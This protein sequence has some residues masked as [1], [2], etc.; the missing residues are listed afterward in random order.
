MASSSTQDPRWSPIS[1]LGRLAESDRREL[2]AIGTRHTF[3]PGERVMTEGDTSCHVEL[4]QQGYVKVTSLTAEFTES[5]LAIRGPGDIVGE[6]AAISGNSRSATVTTCGHV[7]S[8]VVR[9]PAFEAFLI[10]HPHTA[11]QL[12][13]TVGD[14]L[15]WANRRRAEFA[16]SSAK[17]RIARVLADLASI[18]GRP[19]G[20]SLLI[21][22]D[23]T[24]PELASMIGAKDS[25]LHK[26]LRVLRDE[27]IISTG[28]GEIV[29]NDRK[30][31]EAI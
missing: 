14:K 7:T 19:C 11:S 18:C 13:C 21:A 17:V 15:L 23:L 3:R 8:I 24:Q 30:R 27:G 12:T 1:F 2:F 25:A 6:L 9:R 29:I 16:T 26:A 22:V 5:L 31:L 4:I 28:Y 20:G 10:T